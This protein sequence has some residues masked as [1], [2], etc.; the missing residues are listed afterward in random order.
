MVKL[1]PISSMVFALVLL[2]LLPGSGCQDSFHIAVGPNEDVT[3]F[4]DFQVGDERT[5]IMSAFFTRKV[6]TPLR[7]EQPF[8]VERTDSLGFDLRKDWR[9]LVIHFWT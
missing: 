7:A 9:N 4:S 3:L 2:C 1:I 5:A 8:Q 6:P